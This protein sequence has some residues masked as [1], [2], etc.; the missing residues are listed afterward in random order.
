MNYDFSVGAFRTFIKDLDGLKFVLPQDSATQK[1]FSDL[2]SELRELVRATEIFALEDLLQVEDSLVIV[3]P[4]FIGLEDQLEKAI[5][6]SQIA[7]GLT[8]T[9]SSN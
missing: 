5:E 2:I 7:L 8:V 1:A 4:T 3:L 9:L 6:A